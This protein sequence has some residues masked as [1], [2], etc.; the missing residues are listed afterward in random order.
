MNGFEVFIGYVGMKIW[1]PASSSTNHS[2]SG[3]GIYSF[4]I[5]KPLNMSILF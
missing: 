2:I 4:N 1:K 3:R 5:F